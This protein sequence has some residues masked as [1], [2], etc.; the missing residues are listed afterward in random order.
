VLDPSCP[1]RPVPVPASMKL[2]LSLCRALEGLLQ[3]LLDRKL[4][5]KGTRFNGRSGKVESVV[6]FD[7]QQQRR[8]VAAHLKVGSGVGSVGCWLVR[9]VG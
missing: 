9:L 7:E 3:V 1:A 2:S 8:R 5:T 4:L 6:F